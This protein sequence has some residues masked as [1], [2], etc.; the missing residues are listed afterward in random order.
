MGLLDLFVFNSYSDPTPTQRALHTT[1][2]AANA[3]NAVVTLAAATKGAY[4]YFN[5]PPPP[6]SAWESAVSGMKSLFGSGK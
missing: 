4:N 2:A 5:P 3:G 1:A 6:P